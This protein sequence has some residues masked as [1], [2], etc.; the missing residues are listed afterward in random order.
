MLTAGTNRERILW[1]LF[2]IT[3]V[4]VYCYT[5]ITIFLVS[6]YQNMWWFFI[7]MRTTD[8]TVFT[9]KERPLYSLSAC[10]SR[11]LENRIS[12]ESG[13]SWWFYCVAL[14]SWDLI[15]FDFF[16]WG[17]IKDHLYS[18]NPHTLDELRRKIE[19]VLED[20]ELQPTLL[21]MVINNIKDRLED[22]INSKRG[23]FEYLPKYFVIKYFIL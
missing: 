8:I 18:Q 23:Q 7:E 21:K 12:R 3:L 14:R 13:W 2:V 10:R 5:L 4:S 6:C 16:L 11:V 1:H 15:T 19:N 22:C 17:S 9:R 20:L